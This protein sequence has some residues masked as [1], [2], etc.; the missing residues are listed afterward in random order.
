MILWNKAIQQEL[1]AGNIIIDPF[2][3][4]Q[5]QTG[6]YDVTL[7]DF[8]MYYSEQWWQKTSIYSGFVVLLPWE[9]LLGHTHEYIGWRNWI[10]TKLQAR[11][12]IARHFI[13][14][15]SC[16]GWGDVGYINRWTLEIKNNSSFCV[17][18][19]PREKVGQIIFMRVEGCEWDYTDKWSYQDSV[20][21]EKIK[22]EWTPESMIPKK[23]LFI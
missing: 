18:L 9:A 5:L 14:I 11:S 7:G 16:W 12:T 1:Q 23:N 13:S 8:I 4:D 15:C 6:S 21:I 2:N 3:P 22:A 20:D 10:I 17:K 19:N